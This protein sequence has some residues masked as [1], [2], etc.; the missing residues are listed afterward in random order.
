MS[1][2]NAGTFSSMSPLVGKP[3]N[4]PQQLHVLGCTVPRCD[5][6]GCPMAY[7]GGDL[8][9]ASTCGTWS[10]QI[11]VYTGRA[12]EWETSASLEL[13][14]SRYRFGPFSAES[15]YASVAEL[16]SALRS[17]LSELR[18]VLEGCE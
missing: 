5:S 15:A 3:K 2:C 17:L 8:A 11:H 16:E 10:V 1:D 9:F 14:G 13:D 7:Y 6:P 18:L 4:L 12:K